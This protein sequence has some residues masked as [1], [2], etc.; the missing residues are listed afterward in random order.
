ME[1]SVVIPTCNR[2]TRL[3]ALLDNLNQSTIPIE[4]VI[5]VD[6]GED[7]IT[8]EECSA[9]TNLKIE[10]ISSQ[11]SVCIQRNLGIQKARS[12]WI[13]LCDDD[14]EVP[15]DYLEKLVTHIADYCE[16]GAIS[17]LWLQKENEEWKATYPEKSAKRLLWKYVFNLSIWGEI[18]CKSNNFIVKRIKNYYRQKGNHISRSGF[19]VLTDF[20]GEFFTTPLYSLGASLVKKEWLLVS[21]FDETLDRHGIGENYGVISKFPVPLVEVLNNIFVLHHREPANRLQQS[22]Q[23]YRRVLALDYFISGKNISANVKRRSLLW[24]LFGNMLSFMFSGNGDM[25]R[26]TLKSFRQIAFGKNPYWRGAREGK[27]VIEPD[28]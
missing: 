12:A 5:I 24:A 18:R 9:F 26:A 10:T 20:S 15:P 11:K 3:L 17:G 27:K 7:M 14:I 2:K 1:V 13:L 28:L 8:T 23:Y 25:L 16:T 21:P 6:S 4:E 22:L 19:P